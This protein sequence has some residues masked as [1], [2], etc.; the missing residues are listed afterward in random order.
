MKKTWKESLL[1]ACILEADSQSFFTNKNL[2]KNRLPKIIEETECKGKTPQYTMSRTLQELRDDNLIQFIKPGIYKLNKGTMENLIQ[3]TKGISKGEIFIGNI[4]KELNI[5]FT[6]EK[7]FSDLRYKSFLRFDFYFRVKNIEFVLEFDGRQH[8]LPIDFFGGQ[9]AYDNLKIRDD[10]K[11]KYCIEK[12]IELIRINDKNK[13]YA[14]NIIKNTVKKCLKKTEKT[15]KE[16]YQFSQKERTILKEIN[17][18]IDME[19]LVKNL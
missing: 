1:L 14:K 10:I 5:P 4:L 19:N 2:I 16:Q 18:I 11:E 9:E 12:N 7:K 15:E 17:D 3:K 13:N 6:R 8:M